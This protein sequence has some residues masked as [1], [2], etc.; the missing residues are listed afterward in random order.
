MTPRDNELCNRDD[1]DDE[2][3][4]EQRKAE[5]RRHESAAKRVDRLNDEHQR[6]ER[7]QPRHEKDR[8]T[9]EK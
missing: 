1:S 6:R 7:P 2:V 5:Q 4:Y 8:A 9:V 3:V